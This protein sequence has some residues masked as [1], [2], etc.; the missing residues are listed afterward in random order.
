MS[1]E[2]MSELA[3]TLIAA[4]FR[5]ARGIAFNVM[6]AHVGWQRN[7]LPLAVFE[8]M[9]ECSLV[10]EPRKYFDEERSYGAIGQ[11]TPSSF[12]NYAGAEPET[13]CRLSVHLSTRRFCSDNRVQL[14][15]DSAG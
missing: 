15:Q 4:A 1:M 8:K 9:S 13:T 5:A 2:S 6:N 11:K 7:D 3:R 12:L 14:P 10:A